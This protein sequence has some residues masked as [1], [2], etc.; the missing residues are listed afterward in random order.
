MER[1]YGI[2]QGNNQHSLVQ[3]A[4][5]S[6]ESLADQLNISVDQL[7]RYKQLLKLIPELQELM[8]GEG[9][10]KIKP[11]I[12]YNI[13]AKLEP[14]EQKE[15]LERLGKSILTSKPSRE[16]EQQIE[17]YRKEKEEQLPLQN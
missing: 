13:L 6:Q 14:E 8:V 1:I 15:L 7:K 5:S 9:K 17:I 11:S 10:E 3:N 4:P 16:I 12:A 2:R